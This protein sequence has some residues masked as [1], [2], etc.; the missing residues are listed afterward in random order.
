VTS[1]PEFP[2]S[3]PIASPANLAD[4]GT[5]ALGYLIDIA[6]GLIAGLIFG[7]G[8]R[9]FFLS[10]LVGILGIAYTAYMGYLDG[11]TGQTP[12]KAIMGTRVVNVEGQVIGAGAGIGRKF[13]HIID[14]LVCLL[15]WFLPLV[16]SKR[17]TIADKLLSTYVVEGVPKRSFAFDLWLPPKTTP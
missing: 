1:P 7:Y 11:L 3:Q 6:P 13:A 2:V 4:W 16:D 10:N 9:N 12:G 14:S 5:R 8:I 15:G 17:Q